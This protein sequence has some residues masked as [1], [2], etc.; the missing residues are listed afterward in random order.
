MA[1]ED[2]PVMSESQ[3][4]SAFG[5]G[6]DEDLPTIKESD[7]SQMFTG[8]QKF[9]GGIANMIPF[10]VGDEA[11]AGLRSVVDAV[12]GEDI[13]NAYDRNLN[14]IRSFESQYFGASPIFFGL[15]EVLPLELVYSSIT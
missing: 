9:A 10:N 1:D 12:Q 11:M 4:A 15:V 3:W 8:G 7:F 5:G 2:L 6:G 14:Q 13:G